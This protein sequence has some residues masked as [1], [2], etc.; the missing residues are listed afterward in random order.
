MDVFPTNSGIVAAGVSAN[1]QSRRKV[2]ESRSS[3]MDWELLAAFA[4][5]PS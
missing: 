4:F 3:D 5:A 1:M 2:R